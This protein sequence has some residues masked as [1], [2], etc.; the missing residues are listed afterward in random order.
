M[1]GTVTVGCR[2]PA[3]LTLRNYDMVD[4]DEPVFGGGVKVIKRAKQVG[5]DVKINGSARRMG[6]DT[7]HDIRGGV[8]LTYGVDADFFVKW[9]E[10]NKDEP[11]VKNGTVF[12]QPTEKAMR[13]IP[14]QSRDVRQIKSGFEPLD[15]NDL[16]NEFRGKIERSYAE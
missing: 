6:F 9:L 16:P 4:F 14:A 12:A 2:L 7:P 10:A 3:G 15:M 8:G 11:Y 5:P 13:E 1:A